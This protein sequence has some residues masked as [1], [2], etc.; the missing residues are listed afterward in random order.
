MKQYPLVEV[1]IGDRAIKIRESDFN[2]QIHSRNPPPDA[3]TP[4][5]DASLININTCVAGE[6]TALKGIGIATA[7]EII[8]GRPHESLGELADDPRIAPHLSR[9]TV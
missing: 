5:P 1:W 3:P 4:P 2:E 8:D 7:N 9:L 6:L